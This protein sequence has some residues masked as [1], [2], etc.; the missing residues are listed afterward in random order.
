[1]P[2]GQGRALIVVS[3]APSVFTQRR[4]SRD[5]YADD[6]NAGLHYFL[7]RGFECKVLESPVNDKQLGRVIN[8]FILDTSDH[9][10]EGPK[11]DE[12]PKSAEGLSSDSKGSKSLRVVVLMGDFDVTGA[13]QLDGPTPEATESSPGSE[14]QT[15]VN[16]FNS[17]TGYSRFSPIRLFQSWAKKN[18]GG[19]ALVVIACGLHSAMWVDCATNAEDPSIA[20]QASQGQVARI[21]N[22]AA[23]GAD[24]N[25]VNSAAAGAAIDTSVETPRGLFLRQFIE[26]IETGKDLT[27][28]NVVRPIGISGGQTCRFI[29]R[30]SLSIL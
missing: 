2:S 5:T 15:I 7:G 30:E 28:S 9:K 12:G 1:M 10:A 21:E 14:S 3:T 27:V 24:V 20:V 13:I 6:L 18:G 16:A 4:E 29:S 8:E 25:A 22:A 11:G 17:T 19:S 26:Y 23:A